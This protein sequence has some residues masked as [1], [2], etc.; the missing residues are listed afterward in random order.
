MLIGEN[1]KD[2]DLDVNAVREKKLTNMRA[3]TADEA[4]RL[5][6]FRALNLEQAIEFIADDEWKSHQVAAPAQKVLQ[7]NRRKKSIRHRRRV[8][9]PRRKSR[10]SENRAPAQH[11]KVTPALRMF[12]VPCSC[13]TTLPW[14]RTMTTRAPPGGALRLRQAA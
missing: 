11:P 3:S 8:V 2:T 1:A 9:K 6:P 7:A 5:V 12:L 14:R 13:G 4:I 10:E